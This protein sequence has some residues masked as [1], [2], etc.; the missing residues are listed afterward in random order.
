MQKLSNT[1]AQLKKRV[2]YKKERVLLIILW[3]PG[4]VKVFI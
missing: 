3:W 4:Y 2:A 1:E